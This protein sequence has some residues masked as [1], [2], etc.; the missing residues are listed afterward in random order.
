LSSLEPSHP[1]DSLASFDYSRAA[2]DA[3]SC[4]CPRR[5]Q[6]QSCHRP[7]K[8]YVRLIRGALVF[9][10]AGFPLRSSEL[11]AQQISVDSVSTRVVDLEKLA[12]EMAKQKDRSELGKLLSEDYTEIIDD[13]VFDKAHLL[14][15]LNDVTLTRYTLSSLTVK[16][17]APDAVLLVYH[18]TELGEYKGS[19]FQADNNIASLWMRRAN[20]WLNVLFQETRAPK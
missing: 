18:A 3:F 17:L 2:R 7:T 11:V 5:W 10:C 1:A 9:A 19:R 8:V 4:A 14:A 16:R 13:G 15:Y 12:W 20:R 6:G